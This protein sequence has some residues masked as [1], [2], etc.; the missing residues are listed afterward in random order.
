MHKSPTLL[1]LAAGMATRYGSLKQLDSF[2]PNG[3]TI[4]DYSIYD[5][6]RTGFGKVVFVIRKSIEEAFK[7][8][9]HDRLPP[10]LHTAY[11]AQELDMLP[12]GFQVPA[13]RTKPWGTGH[14]VWA[15][16]ANIQEPFAVINADDFYGYESFKLAVDF[17]NSSIDE[18]EHGLVGFKLA[19]TLSE[20][21]SVSR[22]IC[23]VGPGNTLTSLT[24]LTKIARAEDGRI[25]V[26]DEGAA[27][28]ELQG[29]EL[30]SM[31]LMAFK[32]SV[33][34]YF[35]QYLKEF[36]EEKGQELKTE[37]YLPAVVNEMLAT[38]A[39]QVKVIPTPEKWF[40]VTYP[41]DKQSAIQQIKALTEANI[42]PQNL[43]EKTHAV[44]DER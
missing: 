31:N 39:A 40:G 28:S 12:P 17:L 11:V 32:P 25:L 29:D 15:A 7:A 22:G 4:M 27:Y 1:I 37:F 14:A 36:L 23:T 35:E 43:W 16:S 24:E 20:H 38:G 26:Q 33:F 3:E 21:G 9:M 13:G 30:V 18:T 19:N 41:E 8:T 5:A 42:Y 2:G 6:M 10:Q 34:P 44:Q